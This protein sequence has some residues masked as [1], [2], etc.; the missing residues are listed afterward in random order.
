MPKNNA[1]LFRELSELPFEER[2]A[3]FHV[4]LHYAIPNKEMTIEEG[5]NRSI[6]TRSKGQNG[7]G[8]NPLFYVSQKDKTLAEFNS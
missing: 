7:F 3:N 8:Y 4:H 1:K 6:F 2:T 5:L